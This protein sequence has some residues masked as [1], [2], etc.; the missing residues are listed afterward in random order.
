MLIFTAVLAAWIAAETLLD[1][2]LE[3]RQAVVDMF[4]SRRRPGWTYQG[5]IRA[6]HRW[7]GPLLSLL[8][9]AFRSEIRQMAGRHWTREGFTAFAVDGSRVECPRTKANEKALG[10]GGRKKTGPQFW[11]TVLWHMGLGLPWAW[12]IGPSTDAERNHLRDM[13]ATLPSASLLVADA[14]FVGYDLMAAILAAGHSFLIRVGA[15]VTLLKQLGYTKIE[16]AQTVYLWP[17]EA[18]RKNLLPLVLRLIVLWKKGKPIYLLT[19]L[20]ADQLTDAQASVLYGMRWGV[21]V[22]YRSLKQTLHHRKMLSAAPRQARLELEWALTGLQLLG[23]VSAA[24]ILSRGKDPLCWSVA[25]SLRAVRQMVQEKTSRRRTGRSLLGRLASAVKDSYVR[26][27]SKKARNWPH[28]KNDPPAGQPNLRK[29]K[30]A[31][32]SR[33]KRLMAINCPV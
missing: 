2:F 9:G 32:I 14:G 31:E 17:Q 22:F 11:L 18:Q 21:E 12:K 20:P 10:R 7:G 4:P 13:L 24:A 23:M 28:K 25:M 15:N 29:A 5:F 26:R 6:M 33:S 30:P 3:A 27:S 8:G 19:N 1:R 16:N